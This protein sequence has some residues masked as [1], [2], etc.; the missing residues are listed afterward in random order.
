MLQLVWTPIV[1]VPNF[2]MDVLQMVMDVMI[3]WSNAHPI[4]ELQ[5]L[6]ILS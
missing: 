1:L 4:K 3:P 5:L 2:Q 6:V